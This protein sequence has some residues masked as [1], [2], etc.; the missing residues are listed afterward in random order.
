MCPG[1]A[2]VREVNRLPNRPA[3]GSRPRA[4]PPVM[5]CVAWLI[6][7]G[8]LVGCQ[9][10]GDVSSGVPRSGNHPPVIRAAAILPSPLILT[11]PVTVTVDAEDVDRD[12]LRFRYQWRINGQ[13][14]PYEQE[15]RLRPELLK[16]GD[17]VAVEI[18]A[19]DG[20][21]ESPSFITPAATVGN[22]PP[23]VSHV[24][25]EPP[26]IVPGVRVRAQAEVTD[27]DHDLTRVTYR[28]WK[29]QSLL[30]EGEEEDLDTTSL[31]VGDTLSVE[32][33][34]SDAWGMGPAVRSAPIKVG[35]TA[36]RIASIPPTSLNHDRFTYQVEAS[37]AESDTMTFSLEAAPAGMAIDA[38][39]GLVTWEVPSGMA[40][41]HKVKILVMDSQGA[42]SFQ[43]F[44]M[45]VA[46]AVSGQS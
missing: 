41:T 26:V 18:W 31:T 42:A 33:V 6:L 21:V 12:V 23:I 1:S 15:E 40:G 5:R 32:A 35:N 19:H 11:G 34:A 38:Q 17:Q 39:S 25:M 13:P 3:R 29:N 30:R 2:S 36:P 37:D 9:R 44:D 43:E 22:S 46:S 8:I 7:A 28:W 4:V 14:V 24:S 20:T 10:G 45:H 16:R 27:A